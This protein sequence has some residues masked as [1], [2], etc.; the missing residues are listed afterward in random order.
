[1]T[2]PS[3]AVEKLAEEFYL[4][5]YEENPVLASNAGRHDA[6]DRLAEL[7]P[8]PAA[9]RAARLAEFRRRFETLP[10]AGK[11][12]AARADRRLFG[13]ALEREAFNQQVLRRERRDPQL[14][15]DECLNGIFSLLRKEYAPKPVRARAARARLE[16]MPGFLARAKEN[17]VEAVGL[18]AGL[19]AEAA[20]GAGALFGEAL[21]T[22]LETAPANE[23]AAVRRAR[24]G[25]L[26]AL[27]EFASWLRARQASMPEGFAMGRE[28]YARYL[29]RVLLLPLTPDEVVAIGEAELAR[30]RA[31]QAWCAAAAEGFPG[32]VPP[33]DQDEFLRAYEAHTD[34]IVRFLREREIL[35][36]PADV[37]PF[38]CRPLPE[39]F[40]PTSPGGFMYPP[41]VFDA[42]SSGTYFIPTYDPHPENFFLRA[43]IEDP[44]PV[45]AH[46]GI[47]GHHLQVSLA[48]RHPN[49]VRRFHDDGVLMEG[50]A[51]YTEEMLERTGMY[52]DRPDTR[53]QV[54]QLLRMR[55]ARVAVD[56]R[57]ATGDWTFEQ[58]VAYFI[59]EGGLDPVAARGE[60][61][62]A[63]AAPTYKIQYLIGKWQI[64][65][66]LGRVRDREGDR[67]TLRSFHDRL[68]SHGSIP[69][70]VIE[71]LMLGE[72]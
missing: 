54:M 24:D 69:V 19:A 61:A 51:F 27:E 49:P 36:V 64:E 15:V 33:R 31:T 26:A 11:D 68:L 30:S 46:E 28:N 40:G 59:G 67:F 16:A 25:A 62:G 43:A 29:S 37:G 52:D 42:D 9:R 6:D 4:W 3:A 20:D 14:Y 22:I 12:P 18:Y 71:D 38:Y 41:G 5:I 60:A 48:N 1:M 47:P 57:L 63:A 70:S 21:D 34:G 17:L 23:A 8:E 66:L 10:G 56:V 44:R 32:P 39:A 72:A 55:A 50:W 2:D 53:L 7:G 45:L 65:R 35:T 13:A 58:A